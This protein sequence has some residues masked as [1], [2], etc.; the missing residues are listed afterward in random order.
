MGQFNLVFNKW[1][2][3]IWFPLPH[4]NCI[5]DLPV[6]GMKEI[7][8]G[9]FRSLQQE[10]SMNNQFMEIWDIAWLQY[11]NT[12]WISKWTSDKFWNSKESFLIFLRQW[13][14]MEQCYCQ[15]TIW[16]GIWNSWISQPYAIC[17]FYSQFYF[18]LKYSNAN[19]LCFKDNNVNAEFLF[20]LF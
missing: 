14:W 19:F 2:S 15:P 6:F 13:Q 10:I 17:Q 4:N 11:M 20:H 18:F 3:A 9:I 5:V 16:C 8:V 1:N 7:T 12:G